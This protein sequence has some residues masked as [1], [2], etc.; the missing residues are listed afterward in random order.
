MALHLPSP[1]Q[2]KMKSLLGS[3]FDDFMKSYHESPH[4]GIRVNTLKISNEQF[5]EISPFALEPVPWCPTGYYVEDGARPGR[6]PYYHAGL[7]YIQEP[8]AMSPVELLDVQ[9]GD[10]VLD[11]CAAPGGKSTQIAAKLGGQGVLISNDLNPDRTKALA[12]NLEMCG[13]RNAIVLNEQP[14]RIAEAFPAYFDKILVDAPCSGEGMFRKDESMLKYW[15]ASSP[16]VFAEMQRDILRSAANM[17][18][19]GGTMVYSTCT[20]SPEE[21]EG[22][23]AAFLEEHPEF[24]VIPIDASFGF[25]SG[26]TAWLQRHG[27]AMSEALREQIAGT[28]RLW[29]HKVRGEGH[30]VAVLA[31]EGEVNRDEE[32]R[33]LPHVNGQMTGGEAALAATSRQ[34]G[35]NSRKSKAE[36]K[37]ARHG[38]KDR[39]RKEAAGS[40]GSGKG[41][42]AF[43]GDLGP[44]MEFI[45]ERLRVDLQGHVVV[46]GSQIYI[47]ALPEK[48]RL[49]QLK[50][51]RPGWYAGQL[52]SGRFVPGHPLAVAL[53]AEEAV[54]HV[55][56]SSADGEAVR[57]LK[58]ETLT[59]D[60]ERIIC[61]PGIET[62]GYVL[63]CIDGYSAG[64]GKWQ[65]GMLKNEYP[66][67]WRWTSV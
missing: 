40:R 56:L 5:R 35:N 3:N 32:P 12:K 23:I 19:P 16:L 10:R 65:A 55:N 28:G 59:V 50:T 43:A 31:K 42:Q 24:S 21:N 33:S 1:F 13:V 9:P 57:Y 46:Y 29:P 62:K 18:A 4:A 14:D 58:G 20:F 30:F 52:K 34:E 27:L 48:E 8:S 60:E 44:F 11:L 41:A 22:M 63:V 53:R 2:A 15:E 54:R 61:H 6:H 45:H 37:A 39:N 36:L 47:S 64:W 17:L 51:V 26:E 38:H 66:A 7:Y 49:S 67:G 25:A